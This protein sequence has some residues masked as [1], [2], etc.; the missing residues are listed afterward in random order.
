MKGTGYSGKTA[1]FAGW[2]PYSLRK[3]GRMTT[4][5]ALTQ[6]KTAETFTIFT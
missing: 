4:R 1:P 5:D 3:K 2:S 6:H